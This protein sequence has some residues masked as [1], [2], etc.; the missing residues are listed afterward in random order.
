M[1]GQIDIRTRYR[2]YLFEF[3]QIF[4]LIFSDL[5]VA[6][7]Q[8][9]RHVNVQKAFHFVIAGHPAI[10]AQFTEQI[11]TLGDL[12]V[13]HPAAGLQVF[14]HLIVKVMENILGNF[15]MLKQIMVLLQTHRSVIDQTVNRQHLG[16]IGITV[17]SQ[18]GTGIADS[19]G[20]INT[21]LPVICQI[22]A[23]IES[24]DCHIVLR[25]TLK[26]CVILLKLTI[27]SIHKQPGC[28]LKIF[29]ISR[30]LRRHISELFTHQQFH[31]LVKL[32]GIFAFRIDFSLPDCLQIIIR[33]GG[34]VPEGRFAGLFQKLFLVFGRQIFFAPAQHRNRPCRNFVQH[35]QLIKLLG[36]EIRNPQPGVRRM[37]GL[38]RNVFFDFAFAI[39]IG[40][41][42]SHHSAALGI[43]IGVGGGITT[44][45]I[46]LKLY[47]RASLRHFTLRILQTLF[48][49][50]FS[51]FSV[52]NVCIRHDILSIIV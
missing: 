51:F 7:V 41:N 27:G 6:A 5:A 52:Q 34:A 49:F 30:I 44:Q 26:L 2:V 45:C 3:F 29:D 43:I 33:N 16:I 14:F 35:P 19:F 4:G 11:I 13:I 17:L 9:Q 28:R 1:R 21:I 32:F 8:S 10:S 18:T 42:V 25:K 31:L 47:R 22:F 39:L 15:F 40:I 38:V 36:A 48:Q 37:F 20:N 12:L 46:G 50:L 23:K 24:A